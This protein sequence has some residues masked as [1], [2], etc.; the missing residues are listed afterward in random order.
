MLPVVQLTLLSVS[1]GLAYA[2]L[3]RAERLYLANLDA[4]LYDQMLSELPLRSSDT[5][6]I[7]ESLQKNFRDLQVVL[8]RLEAE[9]KSKE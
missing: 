3:I 9:L 7:L 6:L 4:S 2:F 5:I 1:L 8:K